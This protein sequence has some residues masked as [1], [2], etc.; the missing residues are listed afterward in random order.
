[1]CLT[2]FNNETKK[3][4]KCQE[5]AF[6]VFDTHLHAREKTKVINLKEIK[7][8]RFPSS[9]GPPVHRPLTMS[10]LQHGVHGPAGLPARRPL[11]PTSYFLS[12]PPSPLPRL[13]SPVTENRHC[14]WARE[15]QVCKDDTCPQFCFTAQITMYS[16]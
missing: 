2:T 16:R 9:H 6:Q 5:N 13:H 10:S 1:M 11:D 14:H 8:E 15:S 12:T 4:L 7:S 3:I